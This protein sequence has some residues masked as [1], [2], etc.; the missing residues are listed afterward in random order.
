M[1]RL[2]ERGFSLVELLLASAMVV[3]L[4]WS[5]IV[6]IHP[7]RSAFRLEPEAADLQQRLRV[8]IDA[9]ARDLAS[10]GAGLD[11]GDETGPLTRALAPVL[12]FRVGRRDSDP[13]R[14]VFFRPDVLTIIYVP[15]TAAQARLREPAGRESA[16]PVDPIPGCPLGDLL[17]GFRVGMDALVWDRRGRWDLFRITHADASTGL[18]RYEEEPLTGA[19][20]AAANLAEIVVRTYWL[21]PDANAGADGRL[22]RYDGHLTEAEVVD[23]VRGFR[24]EYFGDAVPPRALTDGPT[25]Q[26]TYGPPPPP[27]D[28]DDP[29]DAWPAGENCVFMR[30]AEDGSLQSRLAGLGAVDGSLARLDEG[31]LVNGPWCPD[32]RV[33]HRFDAD[34]LRI[35]RVR[36]TLRVG[37]ARPDR[38]PERE[39]TLDVSPRNMNLGR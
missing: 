25:V 30:N 19:Y 12:P 31:L 36:V 35:R 16:L 15:T 8:G 37:P 29:W 23:Q 5:V 33:V 18:L 6:L 7:A 32:E 38:L 21:R 4:G 17:C 27:R 9:L 20:Q 1:T 22:Y 26:T 10:A 13:D 14:G 34:L 39:L 2:P 28:V 24:I 3:V 11:W